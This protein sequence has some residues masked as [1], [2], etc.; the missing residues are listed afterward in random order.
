MCT[1]QCREGAADFR[2]W[3]WWPDPGATQVTHICGSNG[4]HPLVKMELS[5]PTEKHKLHGDICTTLD[6]LA[7]IVRVFCK[8][9]QSHYVPAQQ[10]QIL[11][12]AVWIQNMGIFGSILESSWFKT[13][14]VFALITQF[15]SSILMNCRSR[16][17]SSNSVFFSV[18]FFLK[19]A[20]SLPYCRARWMNLP[21]EAKFF[22]KD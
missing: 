18:V 4:K 13:R 11:L 21:F 12:S 19:R 9:N 6:H 20:G 14:T 16:L 7:N 3:H 2:T 15:L 17:L 1:S 10:G 22:T 5:P 8:R